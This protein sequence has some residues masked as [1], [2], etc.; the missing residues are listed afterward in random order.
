MK[1]KVY[2]EKENI[3]QPT[4]EVDDC[5]LIGVYTWKDA[6]KQIELLN[7]LNYKGGDWRLPT[8]EELN[9]IYEHKDEIGGFS[10][11]SYWSSTEYYNNFAWFQY[12]FNGYQYY[13]YKFFPYRVRCVRI[14][15]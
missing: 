13:S 10:S 9:A 12:F 8:K 5:D 3:S 4:L 15:K 11:A 2:Q 6:I 1:I 14:I 7:R